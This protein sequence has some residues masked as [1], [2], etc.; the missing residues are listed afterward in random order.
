V[1]AALW[2]Q[3]A[4]DRR[5]GEGAILDDKPGDELLTAGRQHEVSPVSEHAEV[6]KHLDAKAQDGIT[7]TGLLHGVPP[8]T[9]VGRALACASARPR[10]H[11]VVSLR[12]TAG[13]R[14]APS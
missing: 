13:G 14:R 6:V 12:P 2:P 4:R 9:E 5:V 11:R 3:D 8:A 1:I 10:R 7:G